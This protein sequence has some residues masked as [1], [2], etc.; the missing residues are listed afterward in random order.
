M[1]NEMED[2]KKL[3]RYRTQKF[4]E[5]PS[6]NCKTVNATSYHPEQYNYLH[7]TDLS[8]VAKTYHTQMSYGGCHLLD[9]KWYTCSCT[10]YSFVPP[11]AE[12]KPDSLL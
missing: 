8:V 5:Y 4:A 10:S 6:D 11:M 7:Q 3:K 12:E 1:K 9:W 2:C